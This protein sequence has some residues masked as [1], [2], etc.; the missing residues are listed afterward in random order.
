MAPVIGVPFAAVGIVAPR[1]SHCEAP[2]LVFTPPG[3]GEEGEAGRGGTVVVGRGG[4]VVVGRGEAGEVG[5]TGV[6]E[7][8]RAF[9]A[10][11]A[12]ESVTLPVEGVSLGLN[13]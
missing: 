1:G 12:R 13:E 5:R 11:E 10:L 6:A 3:A 9:A 7:T 2:G 8:V 4:M